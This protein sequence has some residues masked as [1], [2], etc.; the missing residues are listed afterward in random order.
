M[1]MNKVNTKEKDVR[2]LVDKG[3]REDNTNRVKSRGMR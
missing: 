1:L 3:W 2:G